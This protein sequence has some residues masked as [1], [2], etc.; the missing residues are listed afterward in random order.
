MGRGERGDSWAGREVSVYADA[1]SVV[2]T[3]VCGMGL[4]SSAVRACRGG[5]EAFKTNKDHCA[6]VT[7]NSGGSAH[8]LPPST[9]SLLSSTFCL[10]SVSPAAATPSFLSSS[11]HHS[12][13]L[14]FVLAVRISTPL[15]VTRTV[16][17]N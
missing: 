13:G 12:G 15:S 16:C 9:F 7:S 14:S 17:S 2:L 1:G 3:V 5:A 6:S 8:L 4:A 11:S 10:L